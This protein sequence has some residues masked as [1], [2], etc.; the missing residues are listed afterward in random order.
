MWSSGFQQQGELHRGGQWDHWGKG[1]GRREAEEEKERE[2][3]EKYEKGEG[4]K[5]DQRGAERNV[6]TGNE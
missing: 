4:R 3:Q 1:D 6:N 2:E 5:R